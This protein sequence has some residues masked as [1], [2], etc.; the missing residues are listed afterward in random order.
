MNMTKYLY[1]DDDK[2]QDSRDKVSGL[3]VKDLLE[4]DVEQNLLSWEQQMER[5]KNVDYDGL[6]L[7]L[8]LDELPVEGRQRSGFRGTTIAQQI[9]DYQK[10]GTIK[11]FP[12]ILFTGEEKM[13][14]ALD[15]TGKD[16]FDMII[17]K[18]SLNLQMMLS[19]H[20]QLVDLSECYQ[21]L[22]NGEDAES[23]LQVAG[24]V[25]ERFMD[26]L[27]N[28]QKNDSKANCVHF[29]LNEFVMKPGLL[30][31]ES[32]L[33]ARLGVDKKSSGKDWE[34]V[35]SLFDGARYQGVLGDGW[36]RWW[37][38]GV[39][40]IWREI[41]G[42]L[43]LQRLGASERVDVLKNVLGSVDIKSAPM[44]QYSDSDKYWA[45]CCGTDKPMDPIDGFEIAGQDT[46]YPWQDLL[47]VSKEAA[48]KRTRMER[49]KDVAS[50]EKKRLELL[51]QEYETRA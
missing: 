16:L 39:N 20:T 23:L 15:N 7:D 30:I 3:S 24:F 6:I 31:D 45:V 29:L 28:M 49:W 10:E 41:S 18:G 46:N 27:R 4:I 38:R 32:L 1:I 26:T 14:H 12:M 33:A 35:L 9:R 50:S 44:L 17:E 34:R 36:K 51:K 13:K 37:M 25:D 42:G 8:K 2:L 40:E 5:L 11:S 47:Y 22:I 19:L 48:F 43:Y 21:R